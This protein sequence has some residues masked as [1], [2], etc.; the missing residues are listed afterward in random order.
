MI[1]RLKKYV[2]AS[3]GLFTKHGQYINLK[4]L[5]VFLFST[6]L[7]VWALATPGPD[8]ELLWASVAV[9]LIGITEL[10]DAV[11]KVFRHEP[12]YYAGGGPAAI[13]TVYLFE[14]LR[15]VILWLI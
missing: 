2:K 10:P 9:G 7:G 14:A 8:I 1:T 13:A 4:E 3:D 15:T 5:H 6:C 11:L 12:W